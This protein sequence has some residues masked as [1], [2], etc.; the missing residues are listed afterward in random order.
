MQSKEKPEYS[1]K[2][3]WK[4]FLSHY[5]MWQKYIIS[6]AF[7]FPIQQYWKFSWNLKRKFLFWNLENYNESI[8]IREVIKFILWVA[9]VAKLK[10]ET[11]S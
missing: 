11:F 2:Y 7:S 4:Y 3:E 10:F 5:Y 6:W 9:F 8:V 1:M